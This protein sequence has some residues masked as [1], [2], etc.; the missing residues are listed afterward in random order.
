MNITGLQFHGLR[1]AP[2]RWSVRVSGNCRI[3]FGWSGEEALDVEVVAYADESS[4]VVMIVLSGTADGVRE[5]RASFA[6]L[7]RTYTF[8][9]ADVRE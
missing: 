1:G 9:T 5:S 8:I 2:R 6:A 4:C 3:T 7:L